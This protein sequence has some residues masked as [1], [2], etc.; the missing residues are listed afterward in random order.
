MK[1]IGKVLDSIREVKSELW[2]DGKSGIELRVYKQAGANTVAVAESLRKE[3]EEVNRRYDGQA[4]VQVLSDS[5]D[6]IQAAVL[7]VQRTRS[8]AP[9]SP[10]L[11]CSCS[12]A[13]CAQLWWSP[14][15]SL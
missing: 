1:D 9:S 7:G 3:I 15:R 4:R 11:C 6:Y 13:A 2:I 10:P 8:L 12:C 5:S 14:S